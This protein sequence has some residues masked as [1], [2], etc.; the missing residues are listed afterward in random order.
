[1]NIKVIGTGSLGNL[2][3]INWNG[4]KIVL[5]AGVNINNVQHK[6]NANGL[7]AVIISHGHLDH[8]GK[9]LQF[10]KKYPTKIIATPETIQIIS[11]K[12]ELKHVRNFEPVK[13]NESY[14]DE[15]MKVEF[16]ETSHD[17][18]GAVVYRIVNKLN[19][20][21]LTFI[22][23]TGQI[24]PHF[25]TVVEQS[26]YL[27]LEANHDLQL[28]TGVMHDA[29]TARV[30]SP[31]GHLSIQDALSF[32][33]NINYNGPILLIHKSTKNTSPN[34]FLKALEN[35]NIYVA[36]NGLELEF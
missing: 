1:M 27:L 36:S 19:N 35:K 32:I 18:A 4:L 10:I 26:N 6:V 5:E 14:E 11:N 30:L 7:H 28:M 16:Y 8:A 33:N 23:D 3:F 22:T 2:Y 25:K 24:L 12:F 15:K 29:N 13:I 31:V 9:T 34:S 21:S 17:I 20:E